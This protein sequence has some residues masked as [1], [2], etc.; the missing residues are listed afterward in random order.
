LFI[1]GCNFEDKAE[2]ILRKCQA[3]YCLINPNHYFF[4]VLDKENYYRGDDLFCKN[5]QSRIMLWIKRGVTQKEI[6]MQ[7][8]D[9]YICPT[10]GTKFFKEAK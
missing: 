8:R 9:G 4:G 7:I 10:C 5:C 3:D 6:I 1:S 2:E